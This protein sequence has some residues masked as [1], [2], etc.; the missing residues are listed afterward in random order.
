MLVL[1]A[2][3]AL[4][5]QVVVRTHQ[6][7]PALPFRNVP[8]AFVACIILD[9]HGRVVAIV[10]NHHCTIDRTS[11]LHDQTEDDWTCR[12]SKRWIGFQTHGTGLLGLN[13]MYHNEPRGSS[14]THFV[15][16]PGASSRIACKC[17]S[18]S[19]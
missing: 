11:E 7:M 17:N 6:A 9:I 10:E 12:H 2:F 19:Q 1:T 14:S 8:G 16:Q 5:T 4:L 15:V 13:P 3:L 18:S